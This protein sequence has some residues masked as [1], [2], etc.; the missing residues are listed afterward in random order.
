MKIKN[1]SVISISVSRNAGWLNAT[2]D[3]EDYS[4]DELKDMLVA[5]KKRRNITY[6]ME[7]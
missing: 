5:Y 6:S 2:I 3:S 1:S 7:I 4:Q